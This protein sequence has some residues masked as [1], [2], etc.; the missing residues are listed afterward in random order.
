MK[1]LFVC[2]ANICR[3]A[4]AT[5][6]AVALAA[7]D[8]GVLFAGAG[9]HA[10][11]GMAMS[12]EMARELEARGGSAEGFASMPLGSHVRSADLVLTMQEAHRSFVLEEYPELTTRTFTIRQFAAALEAM[13][14]EAMAPEAMALE[15]LAAGPSP[16]DLVRTAYRMRGVS[17]GDVA[18]PYGRGQ[19]AARICAD[20]IDG[21]LAVILPRLTGL[22]GPTQLTERVR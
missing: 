11:P 19:E 12:A 18:D 1:V 15:R 14:P 16:A 5:R 6:R 22:T 21:L 3:S 17:P 2:T 9:T 7:A 20:E 13:A 4:Y 10:R 8:S